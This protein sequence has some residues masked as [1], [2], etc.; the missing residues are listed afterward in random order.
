MLSDSV[1][2]GPLLFAQIL[3][4][5]PLNKISIKLCLRTTLIALRS[6]PPMRL[7]LAAHVL[8]LSW[9]PAATMRIRAVAD[10]RSSHAANQD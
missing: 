4:L 3:Y 9:T 5:L 8:L 7:R 10:Q 2:L 6:Y 1:G